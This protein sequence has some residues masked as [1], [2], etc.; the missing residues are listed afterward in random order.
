MTASSRNPF[1]TPSTRTDGGRMSPCQ[2]RKRNAPDRAPRRRI[3]DDVVDAGTGE[4]DACD[5]PVPSVAAA[6]RVLVER[7]SRVAGE[8][9]L[10]T[11]ADDTRLDPHT[12]VARLITAT[13]KFA[14]RRRMWTRY[15]TSRPLRRTGN[16]AW[17]GRTSGYRYEDTRAAPRDV[18]AAYSPGRASATCRSSRSLGRST[19]SQNG[20]LRRLPLTREDHEAGHLTLAGVARDDRADAEEGRARSSEPEARAERRRCWWRRSRRL[21]LRLRPPGSPCVARSHPA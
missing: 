6:V 3:E 2:N 13:P 4:D 8:P 5:E 12:A 20:I 21:R 16:V 11:G 19:R 15:T 14:I 18:F 1:R 17:P 7:Q 10:V 9:V